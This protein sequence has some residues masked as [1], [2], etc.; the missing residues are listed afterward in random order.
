MITEENW[1]YTYYK[2]GKMQAFLSLS[3]EQ[4]ASGPQIHYCLTLTDE[5]NQ[6][7]FQSDFIDL[8]QAVGQINQRYAHWQFRS[9]EEIDDSSGCGSCQ[10]H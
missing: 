10:A 1:T 5:D 9:R 6:E 7:Y 3:G 2:N 8:N 4:R